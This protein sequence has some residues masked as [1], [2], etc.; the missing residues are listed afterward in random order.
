MRPCQRPPRTRTRTRRWP[1]SPLPPRPLDR[2]YRA[3]T[4]DRSTAAGYGLDDGDPAPGQHKR[5][6]PSG[7]GRSPICT[8]PP[9]ATRCVCIRH[10][11]PSSRGAPCPPFR[12]SSA[13]RPGISS[14]RSCPNHKLPT[15]SAATA[16]ASP[17]RPSSTSSSKCS[18]SAAATGAS[19]TLP[20]Q[21]P[22]VGGPVVAVTV[23]AA[24]PADDGPPPDAVRCRG[25][26]LLARSAAGTILRRGWARPHL[27]YQGNV[28]A[29]VWHQSPIIGTPEGAVIMLIG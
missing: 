5:R 24:A 26:Q 13:S 4:F 19:P 15:H 8:Q 10:A 14:P 23:T 2:S 12:H 1:A 7:Q 21:P 18:C 22:L 27:R 11:Q 16:P 17:T 6:H 29:T 25:G 28:R 9:V 20:A 3:T